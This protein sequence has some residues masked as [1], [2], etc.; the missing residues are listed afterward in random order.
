[1]AMEMMTWLVAIPLLGLMTGL[2][3]MTPIA[4]LCWFAY[5]GSLPVDGT[6][7][8]WTAKLVTAIVFTVLALGEFVGDKLAKTPNRTA[9]GPLCARLLFGGLIGAIVATGLNGSGVEAVILGT[10]GALAGTFGGFLI[11]REI[12]VRL[13]CKDWP[14]ALA[15]DASAVLCA[16]LAMGIVTG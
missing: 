15:E 3:T 12:V 13:A 8:F 7:A 16:V 10:L 9:L 2:R 11:R 14:V 5:A 6:W 4:V 1:M